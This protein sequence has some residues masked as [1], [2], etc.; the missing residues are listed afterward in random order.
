MAT[1][2]LS[3]YNENV[4][5]NL[6]EPAISL[7]NRTLT[8]REFN[9]LVNTFSKYFESNERVLVLLEKNIEFYVSIFAILAAGACY[10]PL[11][12][13]QKS[14][15]LEDIIVENRI[16]KIVTNGSSGRFPDFI[17]VLTPDLNSKDR[18]TE[19]ISVKQYE[20]IND[21]LAYIIYTS[22]STGRPKGVKITRNNLSTFIHP[23]LRDS[24]FQGG[25]RW[26]QFAKQTFD[27]SVFEIYGC[28]VTGGHLFPMNN[29]GL[30]ARFIQRNNIDVWTTTPSGIDLLYFEMSSGL[31]ELTN[32][33]FVLTCGEPMT[34]IHL[35]KLQSIHSG[36]IVLNTYGPTE[37][38]VFCSMSRHT[39]T[40]A[41]IEN[42]FDGYL[43]EPLD[44]HKF[45][46]LSPDSRGIGE[47]LIEGPQVSPG[48]VEKIYNVDKFKVTEN[49]P[50]Q[51]LSGDLV[52]Q[53]DGKLY[54]IGRKD[55]QIKHKGFR[56]ELAGIESRVREELG[57]F[58]IVIYAKGRFVHVIDSDESIDV[59]YAR[60]SNIIDVTERPFCVHTVRNFLLTPN[61]KID[62]SAYSYI[63]ETENCSAW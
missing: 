31:E 4:Y 14:L 10:I 34:R 42:F 7:G 24:S 17:K 28:L 38:T 41:E 23:I 40:D 57:V 36:A 9:S 27:L 47:L 25:L 33:K 56:I 32:L 53:R 55:E 22:G 45:L 16:K 58:A 21:S 8:Y 2:I 26:T 12:F 63:C 6:D 20:N 46:V 13:S 30:P 62:K 51:Y 61:G 48:Y 59:L 54:F 49:H 5:T 43:G 15:N 3:V 18:I 1:D 52:Q 44:R 19:K 29:I 37:A 35:K 50:H 39:L 60:L 11:D